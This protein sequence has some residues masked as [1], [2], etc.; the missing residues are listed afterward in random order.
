MNRNSHIILSL[1]FVLP[2]LGTEL[3]DSYLLLEERLR[4]LPAWLPW[5]IAGA[6]ILLTILVAL[7]CRYLWKRYANRPVTPP[8]PYEIATLALQTLLAERLPEK[9]EA[10]LFHQRLS[11]IL[12]QYLEERFGV[13][14]PRLTTE[15]FLQLLTSTP[16]MVQEHRQLLQGFLNACDMVKFAGAY[17]GQAEMNELSDSCR[18]FLEQTRE[19]PAVNSE[20]ARS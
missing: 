11:G 5:A 8:S 13:S 4:P 14:A 2:L 16:A 9:G 15:E 12:R 17:S 3:D 20:E 10:K 6:T 1:F 18:S 19:T 7:L